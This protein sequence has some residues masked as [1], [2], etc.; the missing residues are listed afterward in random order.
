[1]PAID[2]AFCSFRFGDSCDY[3]DHGD[4]PSLRFLLSSVL[5]K[6]FLR[7]SAVKSPSAI[8]S[9]NLRRKGFFQ[10]SA[11]TAFPGFSISIFGNSGDFG[12]SQ[13]GYKQT[14]RDHF[15]ILKTEGARNHAKDQRPQKHAQPVPRRQAG[16]DPRSARIAADAGQARGKDQSQTGRR[17]EI[18]AEV[19]S[20]ALLAI[21]QFSFIQ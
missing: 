17:R 1:M 12:N 7:A 11:I 10:M 16:K 18:K 13:L 15:R 2:Q 9:A 6:I 20:R 21:K 3:G 4:L 19:L 14:P 5:P 8:I